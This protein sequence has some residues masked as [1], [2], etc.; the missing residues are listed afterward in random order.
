MVREPAFGVRPAPRGERS[1][2]GQLFHQILLI[3]R[4]EVIG[5][6]ADELDHL[7]VA[8]C[9]LLLIAARLIHAGEPLVPIRH[10]RV[11]FQQLPR[12]L[13]GFIQLAGL[14]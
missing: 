9:R 2:R 7:A 8:L 13:L 10:L 4:I 12:G 3:F 14:Q 1:V 5:V 11:P 6:G